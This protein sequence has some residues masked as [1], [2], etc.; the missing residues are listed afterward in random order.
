MTTDV[1]F[2]PFSNGTGYMRWLEHNC[3]KCSKEGQCDIEEAL[4][5]ASG[6]D[7]TV[8]LAIADRMGGR[9]GK[10]RERQFTPEAL[11]E[12]IERQKDQTTGIVD[13]QEL[14]G[15]LQYLYREL[16]ELHDYLQEQY[17]ERLAVC[18]CGELEDPRDCEHIDT[19]LLLKIV[20]IGWMRD[21]IKQTDTPLKALAERLDKA[22]AAD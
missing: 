16:G 12:H 1:R 7:G 14:Y 19:T 17:D 22:A 21:R 15:T 8:T 5:W 6:G 9:S 10:C 13:V 18:D 3:F 20:D 2:Y 4:S 11:R